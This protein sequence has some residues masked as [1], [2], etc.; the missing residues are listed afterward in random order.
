VR[1]LLRHGVP[2]TLNTD[3]PRASGTTLPREYDRAASLTGLADEDLS[4]I[5][6][7]SLAASF[8]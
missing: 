4:A 6:R 2:V 5:A 3:N 7:H 1:T 8:L